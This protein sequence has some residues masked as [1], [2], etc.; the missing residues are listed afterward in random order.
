MKFLIVGLLKG[1]QI[2]RLKEEASNLGHSVDGA[3][4]EDLVIESAPNEFKV[5]VDGKSLSDY[6]L[7]YLCAG[8]ESKMRLEWFTA[9]RFLSLNS[10]TKIVNEAIIGSNYH[11]N[12]TWFYLKQ[13]ENEVPQPK[14]YTVYNTKNLEQISEDLGFPMIVKISETHQGKGVFL[15]NSVSEV[16]EV[17]SKNTGETFLLRQFIPND[18]DIRV[19]VIGGKAVAA[20]HRIPKSGEFRSNISVGATG[21]VFDLGKNPEVSELAEK[22]AQETKIEVAG[23]DIIIDK[24]S[25]KPF[26]LEVN[27]GPQFKGLEK[28]TNVNIAQKI[29]EYFQSK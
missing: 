21:E 22:I 1:I 19:F 13:F 8:V 10:K 11:P 12:Q 18:G 29:I 17:F 9:A 4:A 3:Y 27:V 14:T 26:V 24:N 28:Y 5:L 15:A 25:N 2:Q 6:D 20:M 16:E 7:I 23:V